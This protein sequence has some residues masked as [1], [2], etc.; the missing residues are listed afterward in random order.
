MDFSKVSYP[1]VLNDAT[2]LNN[3]AKEMETTLN[4]IKE[5]FNR[6]G[7]ENT[8]SGTAA[9]DK[10]ADFDLLSNQFHNFSEAVQECSQYL[11]KAVENYQNVDSHIMNQ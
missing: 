3:S 5:L 9:A 1:E 2:Q 7:D 10:K 11:V 8:W 4:E 6:V